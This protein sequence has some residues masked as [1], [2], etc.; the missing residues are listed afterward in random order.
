MIINVLLPPEFNNLS[1]RVFTARLAQAN[2][3]T[4]MDFDDKLKRFNQKIN[5]NKTKH[6]LVENEF[7]KLETFDSIHFKRWYTKH[8][9]FQ[10]MYRYFMRVTDVSTSNYIYFWN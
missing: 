6:L 7:K 2:L 9:V 1:A 4:A 10:S 8:L 5:S 3:V